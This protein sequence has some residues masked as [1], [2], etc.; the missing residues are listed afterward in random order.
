MVVV[1]RN[2]LQELN[3]AEFAKMMETHQRHTERPFPHAEKVITQEEGLNEIWPD[4]WELEWPSR[5]R[6]I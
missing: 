1:E 4:L 5:G 2:Y 3:G 6:N